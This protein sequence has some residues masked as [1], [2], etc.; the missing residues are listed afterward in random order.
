MIKVPKE[1][2]SNKGRLGMSI[3]CIV[4]TNGK[5]IDEDTTF[6]ISRSGMCLFSDKCVAV[7][8]VIEIH[9]KAIWDKPK[10]G[11][12]KWCDKIQHNLYRIGISFS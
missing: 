5:T 12:V 6:D 1:R 2:R 9:C 4:S 7:G 3:P 11:T 10:I 8:H